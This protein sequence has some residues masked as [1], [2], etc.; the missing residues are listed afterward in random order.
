M[1]KKELIEAMRN[2]RELSVYLAWH[3]GY[4]DLA[5]KYR[6]AGGEIIDIL[7]GLEIDE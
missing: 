3:Q 4:K 6:T 1:S 7:E 5:E 2:M